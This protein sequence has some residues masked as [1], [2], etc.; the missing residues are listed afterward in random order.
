MI[1]ARH[2][3]FLAPFLFECDL[4][5]LLMTCKEFAPFL[6]EQE[7]TRS[8]SLGFWRGR[9]AQVY[10]EFQLNASST[11]TSKYALEATDR[12]C[13]RPLSSWPFFWRSACAAAYLRQCT[14]CGNK[15]KHNGWCAHCEC[16]PRSPQALQESRALMHKCDLLALSLFNSLPVAFRRIS[17]LRLVYSSLRHGTSF[18]TLM[19]ALGEGENRLPRSILCIRAETPTGP[20]E[21]FGV[22]VNMPWPTPN[23]PRDRVDV[24]E[25]PRD[26]VL[27]SCVPPPPESRLLAAST[28]H[29][30]SSLNLARKGYEG[31]RDKPSKIPTRVDHAE[32][33]PRSTSIALA[34]NMSNWMCI[35][36]DNPSNRYGGIHIGGAYGGCALSISRD[37][38]E[39]SSWASAE[40][41]N[42]RSI[43]NTATFKIHS[44]EVWEAVDVTDTRRRSVLAK[45]KAQLTDGGSFSDA[46]S[47]DIESHNMSVR[48]SVARALIIPM[49]NMNSNRNLL[50]DV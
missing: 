29:S 49:T 37:L 34:Q 17:A 21:C 42:V 26:L 39:G 33:W 45:G 46:D 8:L 41:K 11:W 15:L 5:G 32:I 30:K 13:Q 23:A 24:P 12:T 1:D 10:K 4:L 7:T 25:D 20:G 22:V 40:F 47:S 44:V 43:S 38:T 16:T 9:F 36:R 31:L 27:F 35:D 14:A 50:V 48:K 18:G 3:P 19:R 2:L 28:S 6:K